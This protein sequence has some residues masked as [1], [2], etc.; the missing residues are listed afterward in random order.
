MPAKLLLKVHKNLLKIRLVIITQKVLQC[1]LMLPK[2]LWQLQTSGKSFIKDSKGFMN[3]IKD[4][5]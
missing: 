3:N 5:K 1:K 4:E 2:E